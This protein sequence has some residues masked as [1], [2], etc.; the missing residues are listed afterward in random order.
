MTII[1]WDGKTLVADK[2][3]TSVGNPATTTKIKRTKDGGL[4]AMAGDA[5]AGRELVIWYEN[6]ANPATFPGNRDN[7]GRC[8]SVLLIITP[9]GKTHQLQ[10]TAHI[11]TFEDTFIAIGSGRDY[12]LAAMYLGFDAR[13][14]VEVACALDV[15]CG[16]G[17]DVLTLKE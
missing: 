7:D 5:D 1:A 4:I 13:K 3:A 10:R 12:A 14:A 6:G 16:N 2:R 17:I 9:D 15:D 11:V 8:R